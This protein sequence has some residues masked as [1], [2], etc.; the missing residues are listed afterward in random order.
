MFVLLG[1]I[2]AVHQSILLLLGPRQSSCRP[3]QQRLPEG[4]TFYEFKC[5][6][7]CVRVGF[8]YSCM[9]LAV[10]CDVLHTLNTSGMHNLVLCNSSSPGIAGV[11]EEVGET[12]TFYLRVCACESS[13]NGVYSVA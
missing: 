13:L 1:T 5:R 3:A 11:E 2:E 10:S 8:L 6:F 7:L 4:F 9:R 12:H